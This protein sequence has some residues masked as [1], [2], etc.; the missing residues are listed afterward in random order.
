VEALRHLR[1]RELARHVHLHG[2][3][4]LLQPRALVVDL[5]DARAHERDRR[6]QPRDAARAVGD[7]AAEP[8]QAPVADEA[9]LEDVPQRAR[10][11]VPAAET[12]R[13]VLPL[14]LG[15]LP[16][17][18][19]RDPGRAGALLHEL[20]ELDQAEQ[21]DG[22]LLLGDGDELVHARA[23]HLE[24]PRAHRRHREA[25]HQRRTG[26]RHGNHLPGLH[27]GRHRRAPLWLHA[28]DLHAR[29]DRLHREGDA[30]DQPAAADG[31]D[32]GVDVLGVLQNLQTDA[33]GAGD[34]VEIVEA[35]D[36][37]HALVLDVLARGEGGVRDGVALQYDVGAQSAALRDLR[38]RRDGRHEHRHGDAELGAVVR[39]RQR[40]VPR[41]GGD[42][43]FLALLGV[44]GEEGVPR[45]ALLERARGL[46]PLVLEEDVHLRHRG[47]RARTRARRADD[48][49]ADAE[50]RGG[51]VLERG[52]VLAVHDLAGGAPRRDVRRALGL[53][54]AA[55]DAA[56]G[57]PGAPVVSRAPR[58]GEGARRRRGAEERA[59]EP[60]HGARRG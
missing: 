59:R 1:S 41:G 13:D 31:D 12:H 10:V 33:P 55:P 57:A 46:L 42:D 19:S 52:E 37:L 11:D 38:Q 43:T 27:R 6:A 48:A 9:A 23:K 17:Q 5:L 28:D 30:R 51:D 3:R 32:D 39:E 14:E 45:A 15:E 40:V 54:D 34:D 2:V 16:R 56:A 47:E 7:D 50:V 4:V 24:R 44:E 53:E 58:A 18:N 35:V 49:V 26:H 20:L 21:R 25:V 36:V 22:E 8:N 60:G 29:V